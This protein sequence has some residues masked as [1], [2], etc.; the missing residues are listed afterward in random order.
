M[1]ND[2]L[3][4][5]RHLFAD[6]LGIPFTAGN[7]LESLVNG[8]QIF[9]AMLDAVRDANQSVEF[10][11]FVY[12]TGDVAEAFARAFADAAQ[13]G[14]EVRVLLDAFG[15][16]TMDDALIDRMQE[17]GC[18]VAWF[19]PLSRLKVWQ[20]DHRTHRKVLVVDNE[21]AFTGGVGIAEEWEGDAHDPTEWRDT[22]F[23]V[24]GPAVAGMRSA[25][26][27]NWLEADQSLPDDTTAFA[28]DHFEA[29]QLDPDTTRGLV[30]TVRSTASVKWS[31]VFLL[32]RLAIGAA[33]QKLH[34][35]TAYFVP[36]ADTVRLLADAARR[37]VDV[38]ILMPGPH[39]DERLCHLAGQDTFQTLLDAGVHLH[40]FQPTM[41]HAKIITVDG[42]LALI[43][44]ANFNQRSAQKDDEFC[45][46]VLD[47][48]LVDE[49]D[50][51]FAHD[52]TRAQRVDA[53]DWNDRSWWQRTK[54]KLVR[55]LRGE[56]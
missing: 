52:L 47:P 17:A 33:Q 12:W 35:T 54:E 15:A 51:H 11:T 24:T 55:P 18:D 9:P 5:L 31:D 41:I 34:I 22:H 32:Q 45:L 40:V 43:G 44:S 25:F 29:H 8:D 1:A 7:T 28:P 4:Q 20:N 10:L 21:V 53:A 49:L 6:T 3:H 37:G 50:Q 16:K 39:T 27:G 46:T 2:R 13:R 38:H 36:H 42:L 30:Q 48:P 23:R 14:V 26:L 19:R 56:L